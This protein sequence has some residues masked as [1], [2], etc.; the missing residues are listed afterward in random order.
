MAPLLQRVVDVAPDE[1]TLEGIL[2]RILTGE[3]RLMLVSGRDLIAVAAFTVGI[4]YFDTGKKALCIPVIAGD[5]MPLWL[6][7][8][9]AAITLMAQAEGCYQVRAYGARKGWVRTFQE[10]GA[11]TGDRC[12]LKLNVGE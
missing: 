1:I 4:K 9:T 11:W 12:T 6:G 3:E 5:Q 8:I 2:N 7:D 10:F